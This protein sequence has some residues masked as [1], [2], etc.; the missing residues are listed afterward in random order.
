MILQA[1]AI[2]LVVL[3]LIALAIWWCISYAD[4]NRP[5]RYKADCPRCHGLVHPTWE[6]GNQGRGHECFVCTGRGWIYRQSGGWPL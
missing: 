6:Y 1:I 3:G 2:G 4:A 5:D